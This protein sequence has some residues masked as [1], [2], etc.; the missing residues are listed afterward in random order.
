VTILTAGGEI[1]VPKAS[2]QQIA[3]EILK[4]VSSLMA[5]DARPRK[6][7]AVKIERLMTP[8]TPE[9]KKAISARVQFY[10]NSAYIA[11]IGAAS[12]C[13]GRRTNHG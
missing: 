5:S 7:P 8:L 4:V 13:R 9:A 11:F 3:L 6:E 2:K 10:A 12:P 1:D